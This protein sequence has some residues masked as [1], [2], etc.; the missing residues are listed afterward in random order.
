MLFWI[1]VIIFFIGIGFCIVGKKNWDKEKH[2]FLYWHDDDI[3]LCGII[4]SAVSGVIGF[5]MIL[6]IISTHT[7]VDAQIEKNKAKYEALIYKVESEVY[8]DEF[9]LLNKSVIDGVQDWNENLSFNKTI[10]DD[11]WLGIFYPNI[12]DE[13]E[14]IDYKKFDGVEE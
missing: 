5:I 3:Q 1:F 4:S 8:R 11:F 7:G 10:Q 6:V 2:P 14:T 9:G 13:F 12:Y